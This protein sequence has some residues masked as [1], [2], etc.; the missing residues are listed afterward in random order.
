M[1]R[2]AMTI[3]IGDDNA[4][5]L[6]AG[7][8]S[9]PVAGSLPDTGGEHNANENT[10]ALLRTG[11]KGYGEVAGAAATEAIHLRKRLLGY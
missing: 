4:W 11:K 2:I 9:L 3:N 8:N 1:A 7:S 5:S 10:T 6:P